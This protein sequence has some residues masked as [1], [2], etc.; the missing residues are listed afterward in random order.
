MDI[1]GLPSGPLEFI[2][3]FFL[4]GGGGGSSFSLIGHFG[5]EQ[6]DITHISQPLN[7]SKH[8]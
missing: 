7:T 6:L 1:F 2:F 5:V 8:T 3:F 4:G